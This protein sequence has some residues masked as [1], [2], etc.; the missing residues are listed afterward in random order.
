MSLGDLLASTVKML[1]AEGIPYMLTGSIASSFYG[2]PRATRDIDVVIDPTP[3]GLEGLVSRLLQRGAYVDAEA[4]QAA[5]RER[6]QFNAVAGDVKVDFVV[7]GERPF[8]KAEFERRNRV[9][10][11]GMVAAM[12][13]VED[14]IIVKLELAA[15]TGSERQR[16]DVEGMVAIAGTALDRGYVEGWAAKLGLT[17]AW[18][19]VLDN[20]AER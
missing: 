18:R 5:L 7:R 16:R 17:D 19:T 2:E 4:A 6:T 12:V 11:P 20:L 1:E 14:L 9:Q 10:L 15:A 8:S 13:S 3:A